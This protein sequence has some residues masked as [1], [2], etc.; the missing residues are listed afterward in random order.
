VYLNP[1]PPDDFDPL[2]ASQMDLIKNGIMIRK[3]T[4]QDPPAL[5]QAWNDF[6]AKKLLAKDR[7]VP[8]FDVH[9]GK[10]HMLKSPAIKST[11]GTSWLSNAWGGAVTEILTDSNHTSILHRRTAMTGITSLLG[12]DYVFDQERDH[13][14]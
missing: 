13:R 11:D 7:I 2:N 4:A 3:P 5:Q 10:N 9:V 6:F 14:A 1:T 8:Q 12:P